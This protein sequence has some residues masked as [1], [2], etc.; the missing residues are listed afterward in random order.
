MY[1]MTTLAIYKLWSFLQSLPLTASNERWLAERLLE[2]A[3]A[4]SV[5]TV[6]KQENAWANYQLSPEILKMTLKN[7]TTLC[8][9][10]NICQ[11]IFYLAQILFSGRVVS[12]YVRSC[13]S[14]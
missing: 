6:K 13:V 11:C 3:N 1:D 14:L 9:C 2:S 7:N 4:K 8:F 10:Y 12:I 5:T